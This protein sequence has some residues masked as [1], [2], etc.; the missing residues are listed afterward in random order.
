MV[1][2]ALGRTGPAGGQPVPGGAEALRSGGCFGDRTSLPFPPTR[3]LDAPG[4]CNFRGRRGGQS[5]Q[6]RRAGAAGWEELEGAEK[7]KAD[8]SAQSTRRGGLRPAGPG[9]PCSSEVAI[10]HRF[11]DPPPDPR[12][13]P[14]LPPLSK[15]RHRRS[16]H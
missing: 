7:D 9:S 16:R 1:A 6:S 12:P 13:S 5:A 8:K 4:G 3:R 2:T 14:C 11:T 15:H 10:C